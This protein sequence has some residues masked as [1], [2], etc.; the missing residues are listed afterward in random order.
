VYLN[1]YVVFVNADRIIAIIIIKSFAYSGIGIIDGSFCPLAYL[2]MNPSIHRT[3][4]NNPPV[5]VSIMLY[6]ICCCVCAGVGYDGGVLV[7]VFTGA[8]AYIADST[9]VIDG[10][11]TSA[12]NNVIFIPSIIVNASIATIVAGGRTVAM[13][14][15]SFK[16]IYFSS[17]KYIF[18]VGDGMS[19]DVFTTL[20]QA[21]QQQAPSP[22]PE[23]V[24]IALAIFG[25]GVVLSWMRI[26]LGKGILTYIAYS[27]MA[28]MSKAVFMFLETVYGATYQ[29]CYYVNNKEE[30]IPLS[31]FIYYVI[32]GIGFVVLVIAMHKEKTTDM[33]QAVAG[34]A[35]TSTIDVVLIIVYM[36]RFFGDMFRYLTLYDF[37]IQ[38]VMDASRAVIATVASTIVSSILAI[39]TSIIPF[40]GIGGGF[41]LAIA[42][43]TGMISFL[44]W[45]ADLYCAY[46]SKMVTGFASTVA[47]AVEEG[48][49]IM[50]ITII[51]SNMLGITV[52]YVYA[53]TYMATVA[54]YLWLF[55]LY[56]IFQIIKIL[57]DMLPLIVGAFTGEVGGSLLV[58]RFLSNAISSIGGRQFREI[59][60]MLFSALASI[61]VYLIGFTTLYPLVYA[62]CIVFVLG[63]IYTASRLV[64]GVP[65]RFISRYISSLFTLV[66]FVT[67]I[68][69]LSGFIGNVII[70]IADMIPNV[71]SAIGSLFGLAGY[72]IAEI[73]NHTLI[74]SLTDTLKSI[75]EKFILIAND[76]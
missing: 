2:N 37:L 62:I 59:Q 12:V 52:V 21:S 16:N 76:P 67:T 47:S 56:T 64:I 30:C 54:L 75:G 46:V 27:L 14:P 66:L 61:V 5:I 41:A 51:M 8:R 19:L 25:I 9:M 17:R 68:K 10:I 31:S 20:A 65:K 13:F 73:L 7:V 29:W 49:W 45:M 38:M 72:V 74:K 70:D 36:Y 60:A 6:G 58:G 57:T 71:V 15:T 44:R 32:I 28:S 63:N 55:I 53:I 4:I 33:L 50:I 26:P 1:I 24:A 42:I 43:T 11:I 39:L 22:T 23:Q 48:V 18:L 40:L 69:V 34:Y 3:A 35:I